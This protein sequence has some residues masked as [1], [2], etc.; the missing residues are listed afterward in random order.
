MTRGILIPG[1]FKVNRDNAGRLKKRRRGRGERDRGEFF[2]II[3]SRLRL[4]FS[5]SLFF[6]PCIV[7]GFPS[8][9][10]GIEM[11]G[12]PVAD[13]SLRAILDF[14]CLVDMF[15]RKPRSYSCA[16]IGYFLW[17]FHDFSFFSTPLFVYDL[18]FTIIW[19]LGP[20]LDFCFLWSEEGTTKIRLAGNYFFFQ[21][22]IYY[23]CPL[24]SLFRRGHR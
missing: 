18:D 3:Y 13:Q 17:C 22:L 5:L 24:F 8:L 12:F 11:L 21:I 15:P 19:Y 6:L 16:W 2:S 23:S 9:W 20:L 7:S 4:S 14:D 10:C 1:G